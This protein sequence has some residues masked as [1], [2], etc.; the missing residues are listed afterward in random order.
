[1]AVGER[2]LDYHWNSG[3]QAYHLNGNAGVASVFN[4]YVVPSLARLPRGA[5]VADLGC[6]G[7]RLLGELP[8]IAQRHYTLRGVDASPA[9]VGNFNNRNLHS[10]DKAVVGD[11]TDFAFGPGT[12]DAGVSWRVLHAIP[13]K[14]HGQVIQKIAEALK[15][16]S[17]LHISVRSDRDWVKSAVERRGGYK[18]GEMTECGPIM[19]EVGL[20][21]WMLYFFRGGE[22]VD[23]GE[24]A[25][26]SVVTAKTIQELSGFEALRNR[27]P[28]EYD[29]AYFMKPE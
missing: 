2:T 21:S 24:R 18:P 14:H 5:I 3:K 17:P 25:G 15:P 29:Y 10:P 4:E 1:M 11:L 20:P 23:L 8:P 9:A 26:L 12:L 22:L 6:G 19:E 16:G 7:G 27:P 13:V 28:L